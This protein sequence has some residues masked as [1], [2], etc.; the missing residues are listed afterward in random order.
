MGLLMMIGDDDE[1]SVVSLV[2]IVRSGVSDSALPRRR[3]WM[4]MESEWMFWKAEELL[5]IQHVELL[6]V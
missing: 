2:D 5:G 6:L 1:K 3:G 4:G